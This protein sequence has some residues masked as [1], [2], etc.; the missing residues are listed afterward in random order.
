MNIL[1][2]NNANHLL[3]NHLNGDPMTEMIDDNPES[4]S[5]IGIH[6]PAMLNDLI[7]H[8]S[9]D[10]DIVLGASRRLRTAVDNL[11]KILEKLVLLQS[12]QPT[13]SNMF[14][15]MDHNIRKK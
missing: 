15:Q 3:A 5:L 9:M 14:H 10:D 8:I 12:H 7:G 13:L 1:N 4:A 6:D 2:E 11:L